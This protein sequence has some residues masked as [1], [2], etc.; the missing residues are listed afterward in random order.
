MYT[1]SRKKNNL[2]LSLW[3]VWEHLPWGYNFCMD[4]L[5]GSSKLDTYRWGFLIHT[6]KLEIWSLN[7]IYLYREVVH[8][9]LQWFVLGSHIKFAIKLLCRESVYIVYGGYAT[10]L[11]YTVMGSVISRQFFS[12]WCV[13]SLE[14]IINLW[15]V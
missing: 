2:R 5:I 7:P 10:A 13:G 8:V 3:G 15:G 6:Y 12:A 9:H 4:T 1:L 11:Y 14:K